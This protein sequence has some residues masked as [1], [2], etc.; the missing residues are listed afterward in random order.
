AA[1]VGIVSVPSWSP[2]VGRRCSRG[3]DWLPPLA[4]RS[5]FHGLNIMVKINL[6]VIEMIS[7]SLPGVRIIRR[8]DRTDDHSS[9]GGRVRAH[10]VA[11]RDAVTP[12]AT[13][14][15]YLDQGL[16][17]DA[18]LA[19]RVLHHA[20]AMPDAIAVVDGAG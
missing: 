16:W 12:P 4:S 15:R 2:S 5:L 1:S 7:V 19:G 13:R 3:P 14:Q 17:D 20:Q 6:A 8:I 9:I 11:P 18:T 10:W